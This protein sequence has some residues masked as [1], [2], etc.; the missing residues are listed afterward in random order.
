[1]PTGEAEDVYDNFK[2]GYMFRHVKNLLKHVPEAR[3]VFERSCYLVTSTL[4][5]VVFL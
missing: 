4:W 2:E 5:Y 3:Y 1:M